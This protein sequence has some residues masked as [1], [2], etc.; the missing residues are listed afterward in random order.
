MA[1]TSTEFLRQ[2]RGTSLCSV[3]THTV[4]GQ[5]L[6][7]LLGGKDEE[8]TNLASDPGE[9]QQVT[10]LC[11]HRESGAGTED[12][13]AGAGAPRSRQTRKQGEANRQAGHC[14]ARTRPGGSEVWRRDWAVEAQS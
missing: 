14:V 2:L 12:R 5:E 11:Q 4:G 6:A 10:Q 3:I 1:F 13:G 8:D 7:R 9:T